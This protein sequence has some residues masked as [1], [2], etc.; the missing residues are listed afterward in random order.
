M[1]PDDYV[2][3]EAA[4]RLV[5]DAMLTASDWVV[6]DFKKIALGVARGV[7]VREY[8][9]ATGHGKADYLLFVDG[10]AVGVVEAKKVGTPLI[11]VEWQ[12]NKYGTGVPEKLEV[13]R[14]P[15]PFLYESTGVETRFTCGLDPEPASRRVFSFHRPETLARWLDD[16][17]VDPHVDS[18]AGRDSLALGCTAA[19]NPQC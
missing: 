12:S 11:G 14:R 17:T 16:S 4:A 15:L 5:I 9:M 8:P 3:P 2:G 10:G 7:A 18:L 19:C 1:T 13:R 6:Q